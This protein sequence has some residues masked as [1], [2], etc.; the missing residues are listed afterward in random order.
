MSD[1][2]IPIR[3]LTIDCIEHLLKMFQIFTDLVIFDQSDK[4][5]EKLTTF[6]SKLIKTDSN[7]LLSVVNDL[8]KVKFRESKIKT[9]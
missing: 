7:I 2:A 6:K 4:L 1:P 9:Y 5:F 8:A 3:L